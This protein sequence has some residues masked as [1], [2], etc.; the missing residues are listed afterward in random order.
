MKLTDKLQSLFSK[1]KVQKQL[2]AIFFAAILI[3]VTVIG[4]LLLLNTQKLLTNHYENQ[5]ESDNLRIKSIMFD[6]TTNIYNQSEDLA[7]DTNLQ[8]L[9][10]T[11]YSSPV[12]SRTACGNYKRIQSILKNETSV[13]DL[14]IY[15]LNETIEDYDRILFA[16][17]EIRET[18]WFQKASGQANIFWKVKKRTDHFSNDYYELT[19]YRKIPLPDTK[20]YAVLAMAISSNYLKNRIEN[21]TLTTI[22]SINQEPVFYSSNRSYVGV[23]LG[24]EVDYSKGFYQY[25][26]K[27]ELNKTKCLSAV[28]TL[29]PYQSDDILYLTSL[30]FQAYPYIYKVTVTYGIII[31]LI[32]FVPTGIIYIFTRY[33]SARVV[34]LRSAMHQ[35]SNGDYNI[36][37]SFQGDDE[38]S[39]AFRDLKV[40]IEKIKDNEA[41]MYEAQIKEQEITN[42]QQQ[43]EFKMLASQINPHFLYNTLETIRMKSLTAGNREVATAIKLLGKSMR[44]VLENTGTASTTLKKEMDYIETYLSIQ[45][46]RFHERVNYQIHSEPETDIS[47]FQILPLLLQPIVENAILHGLEGVEENGQIIIQIWTKDEEYLCIDIFDNGEGMTADELEKM[48]SNM[49]NHDKTSADSIGLYNINQRIK[50]CYGPSYGLTVKSRKT[51]GTLVS[52]QLPLTTNRGK[53]L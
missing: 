28:S 10:S 1:T 44:Y 40:M 24:V 45:K 26:G 36:I 32:L 15:T 38:L 47:E 30:N 5:I 31:L 27:N 13:A 21:N 16:T 51:E 20:S 12:D 43:M 33:F 35:A 18:D 6:I 9:L 46:L 37:D 7:F 22:L 50:L 23:P 53:D 29:T 17:E 34:I 48:L 49:N 14:N 19:L 42:R 11:N 8:K 25:L 52:L 39:E 41:Q 3:P 4:I 2:Y